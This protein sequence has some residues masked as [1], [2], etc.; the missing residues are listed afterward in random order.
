MNTLARR[1]CLAAGGP[2]TVEPDLKNASYLLLVGR[3]Y[4]TANMG[5]VSWL[6]SNDKV[7]VVY[8]G[9]RMAEIAFGDVEWVPIKPAT[10]VAFVLS[11]IHVIIEEGLYDADFLKKYTNAPFLIKPDGRP[12]VEAD[13][14]EGG[15]TAVYLVYDNRTRTLEDHT[16]AVDPSLTYSGKVTLRDGT[17]ITVTTAFNLLRERAAKYKPEEAEKIT[18]VPATT[19]RRIAR[20]FALYRGVADDTWYIS[21]NGNDYDDVRAIL[22]LNALVDNIDKPG[23][24]CYAES[25]RFPSIITVRTIGGKRYAETVYGAR[26]PEELFGDVGALRVDR[27]K[28]RL[29][30]SSFDAVLD[31]IIREDPYPIKALFLIGTSPIMRDMNTK[32]VIEAYNKL[33]LLVVIDVLPQDDVDYADYVLPDTI[34]LERDEITSTKWT[35]HA[36]VQVQNKAIDPPEGYDVRDALWIIFEIAR[37]AFPE[38]A[39]A[40]GW[41]EAYADYKRYEEEFLHKL[42]ESIISRLA[43]AWGLSVETLVRELSDKGYYVLKRKEYCVRPYRTALGTPSGKVEIYSLTALANGLDP[44]PDYRPPPAYTLPTAPDEFYLV[45]GKGPL[46]SVHASLMEPMKYLGD[47]SV[48]MNPKDAERL[49]IRDGDLVELEGIDTNVESVARVKVTNRV[50]EKVLF[51][52]SQ[53]GSRRSRLLPQNHFSREG[54]N[55]N[56]FAKGYVIPIVG[57]ATSNSSVRVRK[58]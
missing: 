8:V 1:A 46:T 19:I 48:W 5:H 10:D 7:R 58:L 9:P 17:E 44:L 55:P 2:P 54:I 38:R 42:D 56:S 26:M 52:Y 24:L 32:K 28:Y 23:G 35:L 4:T 36:S 33:E 21:K 22:V 40:L 49:G 11:L 47:R 12:L 37:R 57:G 25:A 43:T 20:E 39:S 27:A 30:V 53:T 29:T 41:S 14:R 31:A 34:F 51:V 16:K 18:G 15:G 50:R 45:N 3:T 6:R 13:I